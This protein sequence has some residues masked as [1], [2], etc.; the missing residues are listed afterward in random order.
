VRVYRGKCGDLLA[1][2]MISIPLVYTQVWLILWV[3]CVCVNDSSSLA[4]G[5][6]WISSTSHVMMINY[7]MIGWLRGPAVVHRSL[8][9]VLSLSCV[10]LVADG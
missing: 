8:V 10:R 6:D 9:G 4:R 7:S 1:G 2:D 3:L 5:I